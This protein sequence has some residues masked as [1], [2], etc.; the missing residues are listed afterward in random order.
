M[1]FSKITLAICI[2]IIA[3]A[4]LGARI[5]VKPPTIL[6]QEAPVG[7]IYDFE[8]QRGQFIT[9]GPIEGDRIY[10]LTPEPASKGESKATGY[11]D[12]PEPAWFQ[13]ERDSVAVL[14]GTEENVRMWLDI[15]KDDGY[16]NHHWLL[17]IAVNP[18]SVQGSREQIQ[19]GAYLL[20]RI[21]TEAKAGVVPYCAE[22]E[23]VVA[24]SMVVFEN[25]RPG[26]EVTQVVELFSG[27]PRAD[28]ATVS[29]LDPTSPVAQ[30]T[31]LGTPGFPR[32]TNPEWIE[33]ENETVIPKA[34][35]PGAP[36]PITLKIPQ[37][38]QIRR[39]EEILMIE[40]ENSRPAFVRIVVTTEIN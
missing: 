35:E 38:E 18:I 11:F 5:R 10:T 14:S 4:A 29:P 12:F 3:T 40:G 23:V 16:Y 28:L 39:F 26:E 24:P 2:I 19:V 37:G 8:N 25:V 7:E 36:F 32:L 9:L 31:I 33:Y 17:G 20:Y 15:P 21:E 22:S 13:L 34:G 6:L 1:K 30:L 27:L